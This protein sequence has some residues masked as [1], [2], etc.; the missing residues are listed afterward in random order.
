MPDQSDIDTTHPA[1]D[2]A[3]LQREGTRQFDEAIAG[4]GPAMPKMSDAATHR[5]DEALLDKALKDSFPASDPPAP[6]SPNASPGAPKG[7]ESA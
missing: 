1:A 5:A 7:R 6:A 4:K 2:A 3:A